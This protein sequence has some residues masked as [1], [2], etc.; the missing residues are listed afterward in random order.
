MK[1]R[2]LALCSLAFSICHAYRVILSVLLPALKEDFQMK[3]ASLSVLASAYD[4][5][6]FL[7]LVPGAYMAGKLGR[8][9]AVWFGISL[10]GM[11]SLL[12]AA[13][14]G[15]PLWLMIYRM[16]GGLGFGLYFPAGWSLLAS[17]FPPEER[18]R[19]FGFHTSGSA[20]GRVYGPLLVG[21]LIGVGSWRLPFLSFGL[22][23]LAAVFLLIWGLP[24]FDDT[25]QK[26]GVA[27][28][29][30][31]DFL[32]EK[33]FLVFCGLNILTSLFFFG[34]V[35]FFPLFLSRQLGLPNA[36]VSWLVSFL[37]VVT[38][39]S[40]PLVGHISD[41]A[42]RCRMIPAAYGFG[43]L[44]LLALPLFGI[45]GPILLYSG[46]LGIS[47]TANVS[48]VISYMTEFDPRFGHPLA[49]AVYNMVGVLGG[50][51]VNVI[52]GVVADSFGLNSVFLVMALPLLVGSVVAAL[53]L[54]IPP[55]SQPAIE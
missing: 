20:I 11:S 45:H 28:G 34:T 47:I 44:A 50:L 32:S 51:L 37:S 15:S 17:F 33:M 38:L 10:V 39:F 46:L 41:K 22:F 2:V 29:G 52:L 7:T 43:G 14:G 1:W 55:L 54:K 35:N 8:K 26:A 42:G 12:S 48:M 13:T 25:Q 23:A 49:I 5:G 18:G 16:L 4:F 21:A 9:K 24:G 27:L 6:Y 30:S 3:Y 31:F 36:S 19:A 53:L 40:N